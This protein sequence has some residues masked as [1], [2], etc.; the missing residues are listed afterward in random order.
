MNSCAL[1]L[2]DAVIRAGYSL[3][4]IAVQYNKCSHDR[5]RGA[6]IMARI[7]RSQNSDT[8]DASQWSNRPPWKGI[9]FFEESD[10][11]TIVTGHIDLWDGT[12]GVHGTYE[13]WGR[14]IWFWRLGAYAN[15]LLIG[16]W[17]SSDAGNRWHLRFADGACA[18]TE[19][20]ASGA[21]LVRSV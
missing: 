14:S 1:D 8:I 15:D 17:Q 21:S 11:A 7:V 19:R 4:S 16:S 18:W 12:K 5:V 13:N 10:P 20:D 3:P 9:V 2:S 6:D